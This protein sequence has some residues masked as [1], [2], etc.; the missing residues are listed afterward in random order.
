MNILK[1]D[2]LPLVLL[3]TLAVAVSLYIAGTPQRV[4]SRVPV[5]GVPQ[6]EG[7]VTLDDSDLKISMCPSGTQ[8]IQSK[9]GDTDCCR[10]DIS[11]FR[12]RGKIECTLSPTHDGIPTCINALKA[13]LR[14][15]AKTECPS[16]FPRYYENSQTGVKGCTRVDRVPDGTASTDMKNKDNF[17][18]IFDSYDKSRK[19]Y[20]SCVNHK[21]LDQLQCPQRAGLPP[22]DKDMIG[23]W[24]APDTVPNLLVCKPYN[25]LRTQDVCYED[26]SLKDWWNALWPG[27]RE[28]L[29]K[30]GN[31]FAKINF[32]SIYRQLRV[33][34]TMTDAQLKTARIA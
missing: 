16:K 6:R 14:E 8:S 32:C 19:V 11:N 29:N 27:W 23:A 17:C 31:E 13:R 22:S 28:W 5:G 30:S 21:L 2:I 1:N 12:C 20:G 3:I 34:K 26:S 7:F 18:P 24:W 33:D 4:P 9:N 10:G 25:E 15:K